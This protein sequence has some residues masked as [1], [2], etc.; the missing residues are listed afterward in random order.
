MQHGGCVFD[1]VLLAGKCYLL[2]L[3][4]RSSACQCGCRRFSS[5]VQEHSLSNLFSL[6]ILYFI[7]SCDSCSRYLP[8]R[9]VLHGGIGSRMRCFCATAPLIHPPS[10]LFTVFSSSSPV[11]STLLSVFWG[12]CPWLNHYL[13]NGDPNMRLEHRGRRV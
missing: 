3:L 13:V 9:T 7:I 12:P 2:P 6:P 5:I 11:L 10:I 8:Y 1:R 4:G